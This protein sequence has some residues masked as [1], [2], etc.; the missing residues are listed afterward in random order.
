M[1]VV[2]LLI[3]FIISFLIYISYPNFK[4]GMK[5]KTCSKGCKKPEKITKS[6]KDK[7]YRDEND[8][9][10]KKCPYSCDD[11][12][13]KNG[14]KTDKDCLGCG[15]KQLKINCDGTMEPVIEK[16]VKVDNKLHK[17]ASN[18][19]SLLKNKLKTEHHVF[20][21]H[22]HNNSCQNYRVKKG[23]ILSDQHNS[24]PKKHMSS[25]NVYNFGEPGS[26]SHDREKQVKNFSVDYT[27]RPTITGMFTETGPFGFNIGSYSPYKSNCQKSI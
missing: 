19:G 6:C 1:K 20:V 27:N 23:G 9:C 10:Y 26:D 25:K 5:S 22:N 16:E 21:H 13:K 14:C 15:F 4:E 17:L 8:G 2:V 24:L 18:L 11:P 12:F 3:I 7:I